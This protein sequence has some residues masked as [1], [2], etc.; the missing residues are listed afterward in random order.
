[1]PSRMVPI[2]PPPDTPSA[3]PGLALPHADEPV[4]PAPGQLTTGW[5]WVLLLGWGMV[6]GGLFAVAGAGEVLGKPPWWMPGIVAV[7]P[8]V[9]PVLAVIAASTNH[10]WALW[11]GLAA[12][13]SLGLT[14]LADAS[15]SPGLA[16]ATAV[17]ALV[18]LLTTLAAFAGRVPKV[19]RDR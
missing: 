15:D 17:L 7:V 4:H 6:V 1:V 12:G 8:F 9:L 13:V 14:A 10:R 5:R 3:L 16:A 19:R 11:I 18:G 2:P